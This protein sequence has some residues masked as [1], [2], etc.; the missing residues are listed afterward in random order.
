[1]ATVGFMSATGETKYKTLISIKSSRPRPGRGPWEGRTTSLDAPGS[2]HRL[3][4]DIGRSLFGVLLA[5]DGVEDF[6]AVNGDF[7]GCDNSQPDLVAA[8]FDHCDRD[9][10]VNHDTFVFFPR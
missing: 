4:H 2:I 8:D 10:V 9:I 6:L 7:F 5:V 1:M 3:D